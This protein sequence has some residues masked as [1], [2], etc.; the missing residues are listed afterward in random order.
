MKKLI[1]IILLTLVL[2]ICNN[3]FAEEDTINDNNLDLDSLY[4]NAEKGGVNFRATGYEW[5]KFSKEQKYS[6][7]DKVFD[8]YNLDKSVYSIEKS[9]FMLDVHYYQA[10]KIAKEKADL[11]KE[12]YYNVPCVFLFGTI[13]NDEETEW[14][15][16][17][18]KFGN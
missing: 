15:R 1:I 5:I 13:L 10:N 11:N 16:E 12:D 2:F 4:W 14:G 7:M 6:L 8:F 3:I 17:N 9:V 18:L